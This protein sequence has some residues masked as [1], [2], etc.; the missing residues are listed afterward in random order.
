M[1]ESP[2]H[3]RPIERAQGAAVG[4]RQD[5][6]TAE[7]RNDLLKSSGDV[8]ERFVPGNAFESLR[9]RDAVGRA[10]PLRPHPP[11]G[12]QHSIRRVHPIEILRHLGT[13]KSARHGVR[14]IALNPRRPTVFNRDQDATGVRTVV[15]TGS[16]NNFFHSFRL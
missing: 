14:R 6:L 8:S 10:R 9:G 5:G 13:Q 11:H 2:I 4:V 12:I 3:G 1:K 7:F 16:M 15:R